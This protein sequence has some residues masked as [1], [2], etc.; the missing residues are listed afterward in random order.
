[1]TRSNSQENL[2]KNLLNSVDNN[3]SARNQRMD[4][5]KTKQLYK[6]PKL[7]IVINRTNFSNATKI[8]YDTQSLRKTNVSRQGQQ[9]KKFVCNEKEDPLRTQSSRM[10]EFSMTLSEKRESYGYNQLSFDKVPLFANQN[11]AALA[12]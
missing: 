8:R 5:S 4:T 2:V 12:K 7:D 1:M 6:L 3:S 9:M 11:D 10:K